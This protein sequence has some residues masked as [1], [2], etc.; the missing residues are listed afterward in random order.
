[1]SHVRKLNVHE[2]NEFY[3]ITMK[4]KSIN[5]NSTEFVKE[6]KGNNDNK[7]I[8]ENKE[9]KEIK[10]VKNSTPF[11]EEAC[12]ICEIRKPNIALDCMVSFLFIK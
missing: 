5:R 10:E 12:P 7:E 11:E 6:S 1:M 3:D 2:F 4:V 9:T 8:K